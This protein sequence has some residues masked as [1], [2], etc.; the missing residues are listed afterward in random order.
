MRKRKFAVMLFASA[1]VAGLAACGSDDAPTQ[2]GADIEMNQGLEEQ[3]KDD[4][5]IPEGGQEKGEENISAAEPSEPYVLVQEVQ[6][7]NM[8]QIRYD[9][10]E[11]GDLTLIQRFY[12]RGEGLIL[13][14]IQEYTNEYPDGGGRITVRNQKMVEDDVPGEA[15]YEYEEEYDDQNRLIRKTTIKDGQHTEGEVIYEY[16]SEGHLIRKSGQDTE[17]PGTEL[18]ETYEYDADGNMIKQTVWKED[19]TIEGWREF[20][21]DE[22]GRQTQQKNFRPDGTLDEEMTKFTWEYVYNEQ[23]RLIEEKEKAPSGGTTEYFTYEYDAQGGLR[24][25]TDE[26][27]HITYEYLPL[28]EYLQ[29][30]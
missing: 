17:T 5:E 1:V 22:K 9:Y 28:S 25:K 16:D 4:E 2:K 29:S 19:G 13:E 11:R 27:Y 7:D 20:T 24:K 30:R 18:S 12:D 14:Y 15:M 8:P 3:A 23:G 26:T 6:D 10:N 21:Y